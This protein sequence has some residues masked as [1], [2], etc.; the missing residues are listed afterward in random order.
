MKVLQINTVCGNGS[1]GRIA[2]D[3]DEHLIKEGHESFIAYGRDF[4]KNCKN[5]VKIG[6]NIDIYLHV[7]KT[8]LFDKHGF[9]SYM[10]TQRFINRI[11]EI[12]PDLIHLHNI[13]GYYLNIEI[14]FNY[15]KESN[16]PIIWTLHDCWSFTGHCTHFDYVGCEK[17]ITGCY[18]CPQKKDYPTSLFKD[19]SKPNYIKKKAIF[20]DNKEIIIVTPS[21]WLEGVVKK[22][23]LRNHHSKVIYNGVDL[24]VFF[25]RKSNLKSRYGIKDKKIIIGVANVWNERKG[26]GTFLELAK[27]IDDDYVIVLIGLTKERIKRLPPNIL[28]LQRTKSINELAEWY[29][30]ANICA[31]PSVEETFGLVT[32]EAMACGTPVVVFN[33]TASP[34]LVDE[35]V[36]IVVSNGRIDKFLEAIKKIVENDKANYKDECVK[37]AYELFNKDNCTAEYVNLYHSVLSNL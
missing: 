28:G 8:R 32:V 29:S 34:E 14:L 18:E 35:K 37:K 4:P 6:S 3:I 16:K 22:S 31:N 26:L 10:A 33:T 11:K 30:V 21:N 17:W 19:N 2:T 1:T 24:K 36:G 20:T 27:I 9:G 15:L 23:F 12:N 7:I 13:H 5:T 25:P